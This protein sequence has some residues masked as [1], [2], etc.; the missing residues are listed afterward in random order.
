MAD[1]LDADEVIIFGHSIGTNDRQYFKA[2]FKQQT[3]YANPKRKDITSFTRDDESEVQIKR[4][5]QQMTDGNLS[6]LYGLNHIQVF[7]TANI[8]EQQRDFYN[9]LLKSGMDKRQASVQIGKIL[10]KEG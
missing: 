8:K 2:F 5:L 6:T 4:A 1:L 10:N 3:D 9:F 7:K